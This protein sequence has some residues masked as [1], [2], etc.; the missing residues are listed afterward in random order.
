MGLF[1]HW[2]Y[3]DIGIIQVLGLFGPGASPHLSFSSSLFSLFH[4]SLKSLENSCHTEK[5]VLGETSFSP[6][7]GLTE[8]KTP[9]SRKLKNTT[10]GK[11]HDIRRYIL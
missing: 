2:D 5:R 8:K 4:R 10:R 11:K 6:D 3:S 9:S 1:R 7:F